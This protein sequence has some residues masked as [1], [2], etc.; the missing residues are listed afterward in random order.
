MADLSDEFGAIAGWSKT[1][2]DIQEVAIDVM[3]TAIDH[4]GRV[5]RAMIDTASYLARNHIDLVLQFVST[6]PKEGEEALHAAHVRHPA[7]RKGVAQK[8]EYFERAKREGRNVLAFDDSAAQA[9][10]A[11]VHINP[12]DPQVSTYLST[13]EYRHHH[14]PRDQSTPS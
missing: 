14:A 4:N 3:G 7:V 5:Y 9:A 2:R 8:D 12:R 1:L 10:K 11:A 6:Q 13:R